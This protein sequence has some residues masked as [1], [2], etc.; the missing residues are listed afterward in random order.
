MIPR[1][2]YG[3]KNTDQGVYLGLSKTQVLSPETAIS[4][5]SDIAPLPTPVALVPS[6]PDTMSCRDRTQEFLSACKSLQSR[7]NGIQTNKPALRAARQRSEFTLMAKRIGKDLS[8][9]FAK[10]EKLTILAKRKSLFDD[11]AVEI[12]ELTYII[13]QD[14]NSLNKQIAQLQDFVRAKGSQSGRHLQTHS[15]TIVVSLQ[16]KLASMS[17]DFKSVLEVRTENLKQQRNRREQF[18]RAPVSALPLAPNHLGGGPIV[19]GAES[20]A[21]R[22]VAIDMMDS[23]TSQ[24]LQLIDEQDSYIQSRAD[25]MQNIESTIVELGSIFQQL[26]HMVKEQEETIQ[27]TLSLLFFPFLARLLGLTW[28]IL[29]S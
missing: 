2:R 15:N 27:R 18:S 8:N 6:P 17:N 3:S 10:L 20:R 9:T 25:T 24:Q 16:S 28:A 13:K 29:S 22:D 1:K 12:E 11:K 21:S 14:I 5:S 23:R 4:S 26:A 7:Q 19:L